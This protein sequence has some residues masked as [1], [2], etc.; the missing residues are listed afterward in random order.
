VANGV[1]RG[2]MV[3][4]DAE[5]A[6]L[7]RAL[8]AVVGG[9]G[10]TI[11]VGGE[12]GIGK[13]KLVETFADRARQRG[14][15][16]LR[17]DCLPTGP[18]TVPYAP[19]IEAIRRLIR[20]ADQGA[21]PAL[22]GPGRGE[23]A[24]LIPEIAPSTP[25]REAPPESDRGG[26][27]RLFEA[28]LG[29]LE[30][31]SRAGPLV[32][33]I[34]DIQWADDGTQGVLTFLSR[35]L[36]ETATLIVLTVRSDDLE[37]GEPVARWLAELERD[38]WVERREVG[39]LDRAE[40]MSLVRSITD[41]SPAGET[42]D[43]LVSRSGGNPFFVEQ[44]ALSTSS[45]RGQAL[46]ARLR[47]VLAARLAELPPATRIVLRAA[48]TAGRVVDDEVLAVVLGLSP[49][50]IAD[51]I[52]PALAHGILVDAGG[53]GDDP[54]GYTFHH[55]LLAELAESE[56][57][58]GERDRLHAAFAAELERR[59]DVSGVTVAPAELAYHWVAAGDRDRA[60]PALVDAGLAAERVYAF[61][62]ARR[63][64]EQAL[65]LWPDDRDVE[66][67]AGLDR[68]AVIQHA[69]ESAVLTGAY[70]EAVALG[71]QA[72]M[73]AE[74][75][76]A[77]ERSPDPRRLGALHDRLRWYLWE[78]GDRAAA[79]QA[80]AE[81]LRLIPADPP[82]DLRARA[83]G[84]AAGLRLFGGNPADAATLASEAISIA[85]SAHA[86]AEEAFALGVL[87]W[88]M[89][90]RGDVDGG[91]D[92]YRQG[93]AIA[94][95]LGGV[96]GIAL[97][98]ANLAALLD[99]VG[100][101]PASLDAAREGFAI[102]QHLGVV[103]T[104]GGVLLGHAAKAL[105]DLGRWDE[106]LVAA[107]DGLALDPRGPSAAWLHINH[108][109]VDSNRGRFDQAEQH[110]HQA[111]GNPAGSE[112][113]GP[114]L[115]SATAEL[116]AWR[117]RPEAVW[118]AVDAALAR[119]DDSLPI[120]PALGWLAWHALRVEADAAAVAR[121][122][123]DRPALE[124]IETRIAPI[125]QRITRSSEPET[126]RAQDVRRAAVQ[127]MCMGELGRLRDD[128]D[129]A[130][131]E[132][133][134]GAWDRIARPAP[135]AYAR[136]RAGE[137]L[138][139]RRGDRGRAAASLRTAHEAALALGA[140][141]LR[142]E[143]ER[144]ARHARIDLGSDG[145]EQAREPRDPLGLTEREAEVIRLVAAGRSNQQIADELFITRKTASVHV[146]NILGKLGVSNRVEA[147]AIAQRLGLGNDPRD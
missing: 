29:V 143:V 128:N 144:L 46:P 21:I 80:V 122:R 135:A 141:P 58:H 18:G 99:R 136:Y 74:L 119:L 9:H 65:E 137:A 84:Q 44:L 20:A 91:I 120:D 36:R 118:A 125:A 35:T 16:V 56:L 5:L 93:L 112:R 127:G 52:R 38:P 70:S 110:L 15:T 124:A 25:A 96:E 130:T 10:R 6:H 24:R 43:A 97:G 105:F 75:D 138:L 2:A 11:V 41:D 107:D 129:A 22:L 98:H 66:A 49:A 79:E 89:A 109:R 4:R 90:I 126:T 85:R 40:V 23:L 13:T 101:T 28:F 87:G 8:E 111:A 82:S 64:F 26:Q 37:A 31:Q 94:E 76:D 100:R 123:R 108:A 88:S 30:R 117:G 131:W 72:I 116:G 27:G 32:L 42:I 54:R 7:E 63:G 104:Y 68:I 55:G 95:R 73:A 1:E 53:S 147:A 78:S 86:P 140:A 142:S 62:D 115:L 121:S 60:V 48:A 57:V 51:A 81:A 45:A 14:V 33:M 145:A 19:F 34:E 83:L 114:Q 3:G 12:A 61:A 69:A 59:G 106:A 102:A 50:A 134:A 77:M 67:A 133:T 103:R 92:T 146:S 71:R 139:G 17:G 132:E 39:A 113:Y 47:D